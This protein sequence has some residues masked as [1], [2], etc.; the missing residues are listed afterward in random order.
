MNEEIVIFIAIFLLDICLLFCLCPMV[1]I[2]LFIVIR[3][4]NNDV[5]F[6]IYRDGGI[7]SNSQGKSDGGISSFH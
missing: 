5:K 3:A 6:Q 2:V 7:R 4:T 1:F